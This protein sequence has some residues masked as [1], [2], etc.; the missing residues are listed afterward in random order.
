M[1]SVKGDLVVDPFLGTG[2]TMWAAMAAARNCAGYEIERGLRRQMHATADRLVDYANARIGKRIEAHV[3]FV[4]QNRRSKAAF[5]YTNRYYQ[6]PV[7]TRQEV[8]ICLNP[9]TRIEMCANQGYK[10]RY[11]SQRSPSF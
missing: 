9:L 6:F 7:M 1:F 2:T 3:D 8:D 10:V 5:K 4:N 11:S